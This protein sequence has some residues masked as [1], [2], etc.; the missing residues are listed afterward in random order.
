MQWENVLLGS[1]L[2]AGIEPGDLASLLRCL[3][4]E[5]AEYKKGETVLMAGDAPRAVGIVLVG[6]LSVAKVDMDGE[7]SLLAQI[8]P[9]EHFAE[10]LC[11]AGV[12]ASPVTVQAEL[13]SVV[14][15]LDFGRILHTCSSSCAFHAKLI[16][17]MLMVIAS[18]NLYLQQRTEFLSKKT[19]RKRLMKYL[20]HA[21]GGAQGAFSIPFD[22]EALADYL[23]I[24]RSALS[25]ELSRLKDEGVIDYW[26]NQFKL[27]GSAQGLCP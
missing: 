6:Q 21:S 23:C 20:T 9:G 25:R 8:A 1:R 11:C 27:K 12:E 15:L 4:A 5:S 3:N 19:I 2:F 14:M 13:D 10:T 18:K 22:R 16:A 17:N 7:R 24:D 26:K